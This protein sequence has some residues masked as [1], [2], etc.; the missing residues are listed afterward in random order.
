MPC[1]AWAR[2]IFRPAFV[3][4]SGEKSEKEGA[5]LL[6]SCRVFCAL[7]HHQNLQKKTSHFLLLLSFQTANFALE[8]LENYLTF[9]LVLKNFVKIKIERKEIEKDRRKIYMENEI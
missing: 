7:K 6:S 3:D 4:L 8:G 2:G 9:G 1:A 5:D